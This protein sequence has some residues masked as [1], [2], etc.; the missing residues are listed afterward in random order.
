MNVITTAE[1]ARM[2][3]KTTP[4]QMVVCG[5]VKKAARQAKMQAKDGIPARTIGTAG[6]TARAKAKTG[7]VR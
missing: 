1:I 2:T 4:G 7:K 6:E 3:N 5:M